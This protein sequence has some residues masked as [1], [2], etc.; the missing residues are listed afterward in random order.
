MGAAEGVSYL[1]VAAV[2]LWSL[3]SA[4]RFRGTTSPPGEV[5]STAAS[6]PASAHLSIGLAC[7]IICSS[8]GTLPAGFQ[9]FW[10]QT[11]CKCVQA[12]QNGEQLQLAASMHLYLLGC[13]CSASR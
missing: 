10:P 4:V 9:Q 7:Y 6:F 13:W 5:I 8:A 2:A 11:L 12:V 3:V 1:G